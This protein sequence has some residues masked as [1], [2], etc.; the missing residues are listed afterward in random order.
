[1]TNGQL[2]RF[3]EGLHSVGQLPGVKFGLAVAKNKRKIQSAV[4]ALHEAAAPK[5]LY[6]EYEKSRIDCCIEFCKRDENGQPVFV[7]GSYAIADFTGF[8]K[9]QKQLES[10]FEDVINQRKEQLKEYKNI[11]KAEAAETFEFVKVQTADISEQVTAGQLDSIFEMI[12][13]EN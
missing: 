5:E 7:D 10:D 4:E 2:L 9:K 1:M 8:H 13:E 3:Y 12:S 11:L 6:L